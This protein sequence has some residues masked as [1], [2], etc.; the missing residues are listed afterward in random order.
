MP[1]PVEPVLRR[2]ARRLAL[3]LFLDVWPAWAIA[4]LLAAGAVAMAC[5]L[6]LPGAAPL[7]RWLWLAPL[8]AAVPAAIICVR[9]AYQRADLVAIADWLNGGQGML[10]TLHEHADLAWAASPAMAQAST[11]PMPRLRPWRRLAPLLPAALFLAIALWLPQRV[12][13]AQSRML[14]DEIAADLTAAV[15]E[16]KQ[17]DVLSPEEDKTLQEEIERIKKAAEE[18]VDAA[19]W[20]ASDALRE[21]VAATLAQKQDA[22]KWAEDSLARYAA[23]AQAAPNGDASMAAPAAELAKALENLAAQGLLAG[24]SPELRRLL[25]SGKLPADPKAMRQLA[26]AVSKYLGELKGRA[27]DLARLGKEAG[28]FDP[29]EFPLESGQSLDGDGKPGAGGVSRGRA[30]APLTWGKELSPMMDRFKAHP[31]PPG[32]ARSPDDWAPLAELP[33]APEESPEFSRAAS[34][35]QYAAT[36]G[37]SAWRRTLAPRH[38]S[39]VKKYF[40]K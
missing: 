22:V 7:L 26:A 10:L 35:R 3:G 16:L 9:R 24:A 11:L 30:D 6:L 29:A 2:L 5:R 21:K 32:A 31:L 36:A 28:R 1:L 33:G 38:Q 25:Q 17:Q 8:L 13:P 20:E 39:A 14:A 12:P 27:G 37:Q 23:A 34:A 4:G 15:A 18:R 19:S 40:D